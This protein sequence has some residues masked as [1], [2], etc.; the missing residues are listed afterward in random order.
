[1][2]NL[3]AVFIA[4]A[5]ILF[6]PL[7]PGVS[8]GFFH[9]PYLFSSFSFCIFL[10]IFG[11]P[12]LCFLSGQNCDISLFSSSP[13]STFTDRYSPSSWMFIHSNSTSLSHTLWPTIS[14]TISTSRLEYS[15]LTS[16]D[17]IVILLFIFFLFISL[18][19]LVTLLC[20]HMQFPHSSIFALVSNS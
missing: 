14:G 11:L 15:A 3:T 16:R 5:N 8:L 2:M 19:P 13:L 17:P 7:L 12:F 18:F 1:M 20:S 9:P 10:V 6:I 4:S